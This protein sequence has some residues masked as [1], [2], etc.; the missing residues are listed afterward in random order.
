M[1]SSL[2]P[3]NWSLRA[4]LLTGQ[5]LVLIAVCAGISAISQI[6]V[7]QLLVRRLDGRLGESLLR[8]ELMFGEP[9]P[10]AWRAPSSA[11]ADEPG[12]WAR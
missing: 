8:A 2:R 10:P 7:E 1:S 12:L 4:R 11:G 6:G 5:I 3:S 9:V